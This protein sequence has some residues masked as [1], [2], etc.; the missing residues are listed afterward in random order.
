MENQLHLQF[1]NS[2]TLLVV[3]KQGKI[4]IIYTPFRVVCISQTQF[5]AV[6]VRVYVDEVLSNDKDEL[7]FIVFNTPYSYKHF[8]LPIM[9]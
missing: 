7:L 4:K 3:N 1:Y 8:K 2:N 9:F 6:G 5:I